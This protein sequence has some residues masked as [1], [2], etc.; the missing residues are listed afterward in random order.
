M[1]GNHEDELGRL[2]CVIQKIYDR[3]GP[4]ILGHVG[5]ALYDYFFRHTTQAERD[6]MAAEHAEL[7]ISASE[8]IK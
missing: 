7:T 5:D 6:E 1:T 4:Q 3:E 8:D 2:Q